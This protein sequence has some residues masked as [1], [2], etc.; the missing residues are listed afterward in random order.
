MS[1]PRAKTPVKVKLREPAGFDFRSRSWS[2]VPRKGI[3]AI[4]KID[5]GRREI[6]YDPS[7]SDEQIR[8]VLVHEAIHVS[9]PSVDEETVLVCEANVV[10][11]LEAAASI[12]GGQA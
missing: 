12:K 6:L 3:D 11:I 10:A 5:D 9:L 7:Y 1:P 8:N 2:L 4:A